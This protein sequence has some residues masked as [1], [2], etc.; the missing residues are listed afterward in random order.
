MLKMYDFGEQNPRELFPELMDSAKVKILD[1]DLRPVLAMIENPPS[2]TEETASAEGMTSLIIPV[3]GMT[4]THCEN[5]LKDTIG[6]LDGV[7]DVQADHKAG[8][9]T[10]AFDPGVVDLHAIGEAISGLG[11]TPKLDSLKT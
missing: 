7:G 6:A 10:V 3:E 5:S 8:T 9:V 11:Y 4:C 1:D 2:D